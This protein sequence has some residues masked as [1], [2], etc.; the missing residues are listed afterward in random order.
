MMERIVY[1]DRSTL[2]TA[3]RRSSFEHVWVE[4]PASRPEEAVNL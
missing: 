3:V 2:R 4:H 1:L